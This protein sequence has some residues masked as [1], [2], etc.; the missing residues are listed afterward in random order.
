MGFFGTRP[1]S[2]AFSGSAG[3]RKAAD[4]VVIARGQV[5]FVVIWIGGVSMAT[6]VALPA[7]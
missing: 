7:M 6:A 4:D 3:G 2:R 5:L 1:R